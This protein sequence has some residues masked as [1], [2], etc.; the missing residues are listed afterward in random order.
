MS[1]PDAPSW[2]PSSW[3]TRPAAQ[4]PRY[5]DP[6]ALERVAARLSTLPPLVVSGEVEA[7]RRALARAEAGEAFVLHGGDCA[8]RFAELE[9]G[10]VVRKLKILQQ[11]SL[12]LG[13]A[14]RRPIVRIG[15]IAGQMA[16]PRS[17]P[18]EVVDG[19]EVDVYRGDL[20]N[21]LAPTPEARRPRPERLLDGYFHSAATLN[22][23]RAL[24]EAGLDDLRHPEH[25]A[26]GFMEGSPNF[27]AFRAIGERIRDA[28]DFL[29]TL[30][31]AERAAPSTRATWAS[32]EA[33]LLP[34]EAALIK[35]PPRRARWYDL[36]AH[37]L[38]IGDRTRAVDGAHVELLRGVANPI[39]VKVGPSLADDEL[40]ALVERLN[41]AREPGR[42]TLI[43]RYGKDGIAAHLPRHV[44]ALR[45]AGLGALWS[46]D[47]MHGNGLKTR[48]GIKTR[49]FDDILSELA[50]AFRLHA[51]LGSRLGGV[52]FELT[53]DDVTECIGGAQGLDEGDL[54]RSYETGCDPRLNSAQSL[55]LA[56]HVAELARA[57][58]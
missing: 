46:C 22:F 48:D 3:A 36:S 56:F 57:A 51:E 37:L 14:I 47:P 13:H 17:Q 24:Y 30:G 29:D 16:K 39:G 33:L 20:V 45:R 27:A 41:P 40:V 11:M 34:Y 52:H 42:L 32:H 43:T 28:I 9:H 58:R 10:R 18:T 26:L 50:Q 54:T 25:W 23:M 21:D 12:V 8:E 35:R 7:L 15:R 44:E 31:A 4:Q 2:T 19:V 38:W 5:D 53:G 6:A 55:E 49:S 1:T